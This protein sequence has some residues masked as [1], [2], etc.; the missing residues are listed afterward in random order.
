MTN[1]I[2]VRFNDEKQNFVDNRIPEIENYIQDEID[3]QIDEYNTLNTIEDHF[4]TM[5]IDVDDFNFELSCELKKRLRQLYGCELHSDKSENSAKIR[6]Y[7]NWIKILKQIDGF[8]TSW[9]LVVLDKCISGYAAECSANGRIS[10]IKRNIFYG[11]YCYSEFSYLDLMKLLY[12]IDLIDENI[13]FDITEV[14]L[15]LENHFYCTPGAGKGIQPSENEIFLSDLAIYYFYEKYGI[16]DIQIYD[17]QTELDWIS[18]GL[19]K[20]YSE[21]DHVVGFYFAEGRYQP[22]YDYY[23]NQFNDNDQQ[24]VD[25]IDLGDYDCL[26]ED[27]LFQDTWI[28]AGKKFPNF[29]DYFWDAEITD[30]FQ[31]EDR[32]FYTKYRDGFSEDTWENYSK[33]RC[34]EG[35]SGFVF[36]KKEN[37]EGCNHVNTKKVI[38]PRYR[39][40]EKYVEPLILA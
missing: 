40:W 35:D 37:C 9:E 17:I 3:A 39:L 8:I 6:K 11:L 34:M 24:N 30:F 22:E 31:N 16:D 14:L 25:W 20:S 19:I 28:I 15:E 36:C 13:L 7:E 21:A 32:D 33:F 27:D 26:S 2:N 5:I 12:K 29:I 38:N 4:N 10:E 1:K 23:I 18:N